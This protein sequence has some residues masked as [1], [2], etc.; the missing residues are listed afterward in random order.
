MKVIIKNFQIIKE[1]ELEFKP[2]LTTILGESNNG[3]TAI[4]RAVKAA[5]YNTPG[6]AYVRTGCKNYMVGIESNGHRVVLQK[7]ESPLYLIDGEKYTKIGKTPLEEV[8]NALNI[9]AL[10]I[11]GQTETLNFW[12]QMDKPFLLD[13]NSADL[14]RFIVDSG[15]SDNLNDCLRGMVTDKN[16]LSVER[17]LKEGSLQSINER[18]DSYKLTLASLSDNIEV[19]EAIIALGPKAA[20][21]EDINNTINSINSNNHSIHSINNTIIQDKEV[22]TEM[23]TILKGVEHLTT[24]LQQINTIIARLDEIANNSLVVNNKLA[25][26]ND[27]HQQYT[28]TVSTFEEYTGLSSICS[29]LNNI[30]AKMQGCTIHKVQLSI[31][32]QD[33]ETTSTLQY[34]VSRLDKIHNSVSIITDELTQL[35]H[36]RTELKTELEGFKYC[37]TCGRPLE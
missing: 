8:G 37:P 16:S 33:V 34:V 4:F 6:T 7:G 29:K 14:F 22:Q 36:Q 31:K 30:Y 32:Q 3:K 19:C 25:Q 24:K 28:S 1:A 15:E 2:G 10:L 23:H 13:R 26:L 21:L 27:I 18:I 9:K 5:I 17:N 12:D 20:N 11:N 35:N